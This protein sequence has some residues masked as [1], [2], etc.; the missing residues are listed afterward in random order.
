MGYFNFFVDV[1]NGIASFISI[2][3]H[4]PMSSNALEFSVLVS[5]FR[6]KFK[7]M[8]FSNQTFLNESFTAISIY[9]HVFFFRLA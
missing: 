1:I 7:F 9:S 4:H 2:E 5:A 3:D 8:Y 6:K